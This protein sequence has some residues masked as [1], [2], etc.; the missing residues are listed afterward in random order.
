MAGT[1]V[2]FFLGAGRV[3]SARRAARVACGWGLATGVL[4]TIGMLLGADA[5]A[6]VFGL[7]G[8]AVAPFLAAW[9][10]AAWTQPINALSFVTDGV[11]WGTADFRYLRNVML[12]AT[13]FGLIGLVWLEQT[14]VG[15]LSAVWLVLGGWIAIR[16]ALGVLRIWPGGL[17]SPLGAQA[18]RRSSAAALDARQR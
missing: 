6:V 17:H 8:A 16:A 3:A 11:H 5:M 14:A 4:I 9:A 12:V 13:G 10:I 15:D 1:L 18:V 7:E 2:G